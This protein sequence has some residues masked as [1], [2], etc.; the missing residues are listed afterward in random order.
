MKKAG[1]CCSRWDPNLRNSFSIIS[2]PASI[3]I[4]PKAKRMIRISVNWGRAAWPNWY[5][6]NCVKRTWILPITLPN[7]LLKINMLNRIHYKSVAVLALVFISFALPPRKKIKVYLIGDSTMCWYEPQRSPVTGW[8]M[9]FGYFFD[10]TVEIDNR[11][12]GGRSTRTFLSENRWQPIA[13][14]LQEGD[15]VFI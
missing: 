3:P 9:P 14:S 1:N 10:S 4:I 11:A 13:D 8:G 5:W 6:P 12:R 7:L 2:P 15:Y